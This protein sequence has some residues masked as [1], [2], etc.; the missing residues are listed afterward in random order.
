VEISH[1]ASSLRQVGIGNLLV[2]DVT[3]TEQNV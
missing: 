3:K 1:T 2:V